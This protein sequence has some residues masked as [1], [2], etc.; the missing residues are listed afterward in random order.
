MHRETFSHENNR[1]DTVPALKFTSRV[2]KNAI[3]IA[4]AM[5]DCFA[6]QR[7]MQPQSVQ[8]RADFP[9]PLDMTGRNEQPQ[10]WKLPAQAQKNLS[11]DFL[12]T[13]MRAAAEDDGRV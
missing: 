2:K 1:G 12:F 9:Y 5:S 6:C 3:H 4:F 11:E 13:A 8:L 10:C 7:H